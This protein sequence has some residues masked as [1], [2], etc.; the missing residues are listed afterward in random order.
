MMPH[1]STRTTAPAVV[2]AIVA[3]AGKRH[4]GAV[5][6]DAVSP[7]ALPTA[8]APRGAATCP[9][10]AAGLSWPEY[11]DVVVCASCGSTLA[12]DAALRAVRCPQ[13]AGSLA[14]IGGTRLLACCHCGVHVYVSP[15]AGVD[16]WRLPLRVGAREAQDVA[17]C[18]LQER[19][20]LAPAAR[21]ARFSLVRQVYVPIW[22]YR[23]LVAGWEFGYTSRVR[24]EYVGD[25]E[26]ERLELRAVREAVQDARLNERRHY[27]CG[28]DLGLVGG[29]RPRVTGRE[30]LLPLLAG[31]LDGALVLEHRGSVDEIR[32]RGHRFALQPASMAERPDARLYALR[33]AVTL[34]FYPLW[35]LE[36]EVGGHQFAV[37]VNGFEAAVH[38]ADAPAGGIHAL[39]AR[40]ASLVG[41]RIQG[42][43]EYHD[44]F[45][46]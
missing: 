23:A 22:E 35:R 27:E 9:Q 26:N 32:A 31:D 7:G 40:L 3:A 4:D 18:W 25:P 16:R 29:A 10:C 38:A 12:A 13:C 43:V 24:G 37:V 20:G 36:Y 17:R 34:L 8:A 6:D 11:A 2:P 15:R 45:A 1:G 42:T 33:E 46:S 19:P 21:R 28:A 30:P 5:P 39:Q 14:A 44:P 41:Q